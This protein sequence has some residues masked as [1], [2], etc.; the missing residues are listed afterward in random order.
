MSLLHPRV[1]YLS[2]LQWYALARKQKASFFQ[3][4]NHFIN[5][6][7]RKCS[8]I[9]AG[10]C[11]SSKTIFCNIVHINININCVS[12]PLICCK[13]HKCAWTT[14]TSAKLS[15]IEPLKKKVKKWLLH[16]L[17]ENTPVGNNIIWQDSYLNNNLQLTKNNFKDGIHLKNS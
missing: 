9:Q 14:W 17:E 16:K 2:K 6:I 10:V 12:L 4:P 5:S 13:Q 1:N 8:I 7:N 11:I 15:K 3:L